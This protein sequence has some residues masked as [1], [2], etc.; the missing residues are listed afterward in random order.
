MISF[1][2]PG[3]TRILILFGYH[4]FF[5]TRETAIHDGINELFQKIFLRIITYQKM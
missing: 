1:N 2:D 5:Y 3:I 4:A